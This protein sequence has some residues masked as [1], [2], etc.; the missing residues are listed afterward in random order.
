MEHHEKYMRLAMAEAE[1]ALQKGDFPVGCVFV[2][3][4]Q[5]ISSGRRQNSSG[6][7]ANELDHAEIVTL[8]ELLQKQPQYDLAGVTVYSTMEPCLMCFSTLLLSGLRNFV[9]SYEDVMGG[10][11]SLPLD[12]LPQLYSKMDVSILPHV[13]RFESL[14]LFQDFFRNYDYWAKSDLARYTLEQNQET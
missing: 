9:W 3:T 7:N 4:G 13:L 14:K 2:N 10:G 12:Q 11:T 6:E 5:I 8:R 1:K